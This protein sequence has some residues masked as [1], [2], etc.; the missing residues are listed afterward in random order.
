M[1]AGKFYLVTG[2]VETSNYNR[3]TT[4]RT[5]MRIVI[6]VDEAEAVDKFDAALSKDDPY[7]STESACAHAC[8]E[9]IV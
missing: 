3:K 2:T 7:G 4:T 8:H 6:A 9:A 5:E 1:T